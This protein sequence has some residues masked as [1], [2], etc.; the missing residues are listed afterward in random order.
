[1]PSAKQKPSD[2][3]GEAKRH[4]MPLIFKY[5]I[6]DSKT[7]YF[8]PDSSVI[9]VGSDKRTQQRLRVAVVEGDPVDYALGWYQYTENDPSVRNSIKR[10]PVVNM[11]NERRAGGDWES[12]LMAPEEC[13]SRR[14]N[15]VQALTM[16][17]S[18]QTENLYPIPQ[19]GGIYSPQVYVF[20]DGPDNNYAHWKEM[21][22]LP[23]I[24]VAPVRRPKLDEAGTNYS[25]IQEKELMIEKMRTVLRIAVYCGHTSL[26]IG[27]FGVGPIFRNPVDE[28]AKMWRKLLFEEPEFSGVFTDVVFAIEKSLVGGSAKGA[29][30]EL[31]I[32]KKEFDPSTIFPTRYR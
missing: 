30:S 19:R 12:G 15:L 29:L 17:W 10:I 2:I 21:K 26:C 3:A 14:S 6:K 32:F 5:H 9:K 22:W 24:S 8:Y 18:S 23:V 25:F 1:M 7:S 16:T 20:R 31:E 11:A 28:V 13:F 27:A 4:Y